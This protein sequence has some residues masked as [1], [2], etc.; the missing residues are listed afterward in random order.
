M[1]EAVASL[2]L[3][4]ILLG[5]EGI[6]AADRVEKA[7][8]DVW[9]LSEEMGSKLLLPHVHL[10]RSQLAHLRGDEATKQREL[11]SAHQLFVETGATG[12]A[13]RLAEKLGL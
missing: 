11:R 12:H 4:R 5:T 9:H 7:L 3:T 6:D 13:R 2:A 1:A 10:E 8:S